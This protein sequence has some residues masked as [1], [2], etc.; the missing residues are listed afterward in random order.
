MKR[1]T[2]KIRTEQ[3]ADKAHRHLLNVP[4]DAVVIKSCAQWACRTKLTEKEKEINGSNYS[5]CQFLP[6][7]AAM[8]ARSWES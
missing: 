7:D 8:L 4:D 2:T 6:R 1:Q 5:L 3:H